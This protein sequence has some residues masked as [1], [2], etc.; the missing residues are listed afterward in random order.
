[1]TFELIKM[2]ALQALYV[3][4]V[5]I[6][7]LRIIKYIAKKIKKG[8]DKT[9]LDETLKPFLVSLTRN[10]LKILL[11][12]SIIKMVGVDITSF[13]AI[14]GAASFAVG[15]A[16]QGTL[17]NFS[18]GVLLLTL[19]PFKVGDFIEAIGYSG[20]VE[21]I[22]IFTTTLVTPD[23]RVILIPNGGLSNT[24]I[25]NYSVKSTRR[26]D[27]SF[28]VGYE[29]DILKAKEVLLDIIQKH[30][31]IQNK[32]EPFVKVSEH[33]DSAVFFVVRVWAKSADYWT[34]YFDLLEQVKIRFDEEKISIPYPQMD[35][36]I[37]QDND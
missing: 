13:V 24:S 12:L 33:G 27:L 10:M 11:I 23:N 19:R 6:I 17:A 30:D 20:T 34:V 28:G 35:V 14:I 26:V 1:M 3:I 36:H 25:I 29:V 21:S 2:Y 15:L 37:E 22:Q 8:L 9:S 31:D 4:V 18:G 5:L 32:P 16:F 7:G